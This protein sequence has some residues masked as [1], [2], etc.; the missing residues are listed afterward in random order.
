ME[1]SLS[2]EGNHFSQMYREYTGRNNHQ[3]LTNLELIKQRIP[4]HRYAIKVPIIPGY[5]D[6]KSQQDSIYKLH[7]IG[8]DPDTIIPFTY[9][10]NV[11]SE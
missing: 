4:I 2:V 8:I 9:I 6:E 11:I 5:A 1:E 3:V 7:E 10:S